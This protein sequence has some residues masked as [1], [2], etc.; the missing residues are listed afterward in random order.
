MNNSDADC[1]QSKKKLQMS[2]DLL[3]IKLLYNFDCIYHQ[4]LI[5]NPNAISDQVTEEKI[6][7][8]ASL[9]VT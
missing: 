7:Q 9:M 1:S 8:I 4:F 5:S 6:K 3:K 2:K